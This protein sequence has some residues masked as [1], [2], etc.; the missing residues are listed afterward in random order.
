MK[1]NMLLS[2]KLFMHVGMFNKEARWLVA[3][4]VD[5]LHLP[6]SQRLF[7]PMQMLPPKY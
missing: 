1:T 7:K 5:E 2:E 3:A 4:I 6:M